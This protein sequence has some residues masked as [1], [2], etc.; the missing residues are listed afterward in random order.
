MAKNNVPIIKPHMLDERIKSL[1]AT[2][3]RIIADMLHGQARYYYHLATRKDKIYKEYENQ[4]RRYNLAIKDC[5][6]ALKHGV[7]IW[8]AINKVATA[9]DLPSQDLHNRIY[10]IKK[11]RV[12]QEIQRHRRNM[13]IIKQISQ[14]IQIQEIAKLHNLHRT[15]I[16]RIEKNAKRRQ[17]W[18]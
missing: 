14:G 2:S 6:K 9:Y 7:P 17:W 15:T 3:C 16:Y 5:I 18:L 4:Q 11:E 8:Q 12:E 1:D 13:D 10:E